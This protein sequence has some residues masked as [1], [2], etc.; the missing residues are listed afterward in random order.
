MIRQCALILLLTLGLA[1]VASGGVLNVPGDYAQINDA[2]QACAP[3]DTVLV[4][5]GTWHDCTHPTEGP[6]TTPASVIMKS[7]VTL[8]GAGPDQTIIDAQSLGR[9]I[10]IEAV[11]DCR[12]E[13][14]RVT[15]AF[16]SIYGAGILVRNVDATV[17]VTDVRVTGCTDGGVIC[18][19]GASPVL[20][21]VVMDNNSAKQGGGLAIEESSSPQVI[22]CVV[23]A[24]TAPSGAG[25]FIRQNCA[26]VLSGCLITGNAITANWG[27]GGGISVQSSTPQILGCEITDNTTLGYGG[28]VAYLD[29]A[30]GLME[31]CL[32]QG[33][34]GAF[35]YSQGGGIATS[36][37][38]PT[39][40]RVVI[41]GNTASG[42]FA[43]GGGIDISFAPA[44]TLE[45]CTI[46][47]NA[48]SPNGFGGGISVQWSAAPV[49][50]RC[51]IA[52]ATAGQGLFCSSATPVV[53]CTDIYGNAAGDA[54]CGTDAGGNFSADPLFCGSAGHEYNL[55]P[56]S[57]CAP[58][59]H[60]GGL[61]GG[62]LIGALAA[63]CGES[64]VPDAALAGLG[65]DN[66][67][68]PFNP[69]TTIVFSLPA[70]GPAVL[71]VFDLQGR[72][73]HHAAW[74]RLDAGRHE[75]RWNGTDRSGRAL[76][77]G[78]Y[79]YRLDSGQ[80]S[81]TRRMSLIR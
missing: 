55:D 11:S 57:P 48:T 41:V 78:L 43:E 56:A 34:D 50:D 1:G 27:N 36:A 75:H 23:E 21:R 71:R 70:D 64:P 9:G 52:F 20:T 51:I 79:L 31:D 58:G 10:F 46:A 45:S 47:G 12:V 66:Y 76:A 8:R 2:V 38:G 24:N 42:F 60:P 14:L 77:S 40:R 59:N 19:T 54:L 61:C 17:A 49:I 80:L 68:N 81:L 44:P 25:V 65:L 39:L 35:T 15:G 74:D 72:L 22:D 32:V 16:A 26:P 4:A 69:M 37:A 30:A 73:V 29:G 18:I 3:G 28:G 33:N 53:S 62:D 5:A 67:P 13:N 7:G 6:G 63:G